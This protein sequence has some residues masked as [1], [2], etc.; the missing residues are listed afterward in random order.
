MNM[1]YMRLTFLS[2]ILLLFLAM[3]SMAEYTSPRLDSLQL[4]EDS[5]SLQVQEL[6]HQRD[7]VLNLLKDCKTESEFSV[8]LS[9]FE[10]IEKRQGQIANIIEKITNEKA[11]EWARLE[12]IERDSILSEK[13]A[14]VQ[15]LSPVM[16]QGEHKGHAWV[17]LG[18]PSGTKWATY[19]VGTTKIHGV[20]TR[21]AWGETASKKLYSPTTCP[22]FD[23]DL[24]NYTGMAQYD[25]ATAQWGE[26]W[27]TPTKEQWDELVEYCLWEY[28]TINGINGVLFTSKKTH[29]YIFLPSTG[30]TDQ[31][32]TYK[33]IYTTYN[34]GY[35]SSTSRD[36][37]VAYSYLANYEY[38]AVAAGT[39]KY[40]GF[41]VR[42][43]CTVQ[44]P[45]NPDASSIGLE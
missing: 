16:L 22:L 9:A 38:G 37:R 15:S 40:N 44:A 18:L 3:P 35:W 10:K 19:N 34:L 7:S 1:R 17:D 11:V 24:P 36:S 4:V 14:Q 33:V 30:I 21:V 39:Y 41:C 45:A 29:H 27:Y 31:D 25:L 2:T 8:Q 32:N 12:H 42:A 28:V 43:V 5:Y 13:R 23:V 20:G 6:F 26:G